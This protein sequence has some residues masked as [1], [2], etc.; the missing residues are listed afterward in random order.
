MADAEL[1]NNQV[2]HLEIIQSVITRMAEDSFA[3]RRWSI[4]TTAALVALAFAEDE[5]ILAFAAI[6]PC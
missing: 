4:P 1:T 3:V 2:K 5:A 6:S